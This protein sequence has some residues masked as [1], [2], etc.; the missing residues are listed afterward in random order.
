MSDVLDQSERKL[1]HC[2]GLLLL[3]INNFVRLKNDGNHDKPLEV[4]KI[5]TSNGFPTMVFS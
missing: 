3:Y 1:V 4:L 2:G 5:M